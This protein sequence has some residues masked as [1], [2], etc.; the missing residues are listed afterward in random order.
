MS[1]IISF[2]VHFTQVK[3][4]LMVMWGNTTHSANVA[5]HLCSISLTCQLVVNRIEG[6]LPM[7]TRLQS[8]WSFLVLRSSTDS[9]WRMTLPIGIKNSS[10]FS[11]KIA[12]LS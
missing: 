9:F 1:L 11:L 6:R 4:S 12:A 5:L 3:S 2:K 10:R 7:K 8:L